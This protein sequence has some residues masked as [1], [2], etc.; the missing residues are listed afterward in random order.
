MTKDQEASK[1]LKKLETMTD[2]FFLTVFDLETRGPG[3]ILGIR[4]S[5]LPNFVLGD[6]NKDK[7]MME[8]CIEDAKEI[9]ERKSDAPILRVVKDSIEKAQYFD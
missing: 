8:V 3:D 4:Q 9:L 6:L 5:G 2:G 7:A 1:R